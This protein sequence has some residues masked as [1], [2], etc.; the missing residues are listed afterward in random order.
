MGCLGAIAKFPIEEWSDEITEMKR[1]KLYKIYEIRNILQKRKQY[2]IKLR[3]PM[4]ELMDY[5]KFIRFE[6]D[7][8]RDVQIRRKKLKILEGRNNIELRLFK[9]IKNLFENAVRRFTDYKLCLTYIRF[10]KSS[11]FEPDMEH[12]EYIV[13]SFPEVSTV[14]LE[15][16][17]WV[18]KKSIREAI[19]LIN[20]ALVLNPTYS[21]LHNE[22]IK[23]ELLS[24]NRVCSRE[25][26]QK[27][28][29]IYCKKI[30]LYLDEFFENVYD[31]RGLV[32]VLE[33]LEVYP[34]T[35]LLQYR[36]IEKMMTDFVNE[37][38]VWQFLGE[39]EK[40]GKHYPIPCDDDSLKS[41]T[42]CLTR[43]IEKY[44]QGIVHICPS[45]K[46]ELW[47][48][49]LDCLIDL[50]YFYKNDNEL[51]F[52][53]IQ[54]ILFQKFHEATEDSSLVLDEDHYSMC[55]DLEE[56]L[57]D[58]L[59]IV[60]IGL[61]VLP[62]SIELWKLKLE[63]LLKKDVSQIKEQFKKGI[64]ILKEESAPLWRMIINYHL[65]YSSINTIKEI[66][67]EAIKQPEEISN[68][69]KPEY[70]EWVGTNLGIRAAREVYKEIS[71]TLPFCK[72]L[73]EEMFKLERKEFYIDVQDLERPLLLAC[74][75]FGHLDS[76]VWINLRN[77]YYQFIYLFKIEIP[78]FN[79]KAKYLH[80]GFEAEKALKDNEEMLIKF[81]N[82]Y[83]LGKQLVTKSYQSSFDN[84][85]LN[86][87][88][89]PSFYKVLADLN[90]YD[91]DD[92]DDL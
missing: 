37:E 30:N 8:V 73:H 67:E 82:S 25:E 72:N 40:N 27:R 20:R 52:S 2:E 60:E 66:Y 53:F 88:V 45:K 79:I 83:G 36:I 44:E 65:N 22:V 14:W 56:E 46:S 29:E 26:L 21:I 59:K 19:S 84:R 13:T 35:I 85:Y 11:N 68:V 57:D 9:K 38:E 63:I 55:A 74:H 77:C 24:T 16:A 54:N 12:V 61:A 34:Y 42:F 18:R 48:L 78:D 7:L 80:I 86:F 58:K 5:T 1:L 50:Y 28:H 6:K 32:R 70:L 76:E 62:T 64:L 15:S 43:C 90:D 75:Q 87:E 71:E 69:I 89:I 31:Y 92:D 49:F 4:Q 10:C 33:T 51:L 41:T 17:S 91:S 3:G 23:L 81:R 39:R 47:K